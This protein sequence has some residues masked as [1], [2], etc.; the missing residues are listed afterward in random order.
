MK[1]ITIGLLTYNRASV[2]PRAIE[3]AINQTYSNLE[4]I[5][6]D[7][8]SSD[9]TYNVILPYLNDSRVRYIRRPS[10]GMTQN[11]IQ[12]LNDARGEYFMWLCDDDYLSNNYI[13]RNYFFLAQNPDFSLSCG[14]TIFFNER[15]FLDR[16]EYIDLKDNSSIKRIIKYFNEVNSNIILYGLMRREQILELSYPNVFGADII[17]SCQIVFMG[18][19][20]IDNDTLFYYSTQGISDNT[21]TLSKYYQSN[22]IKRNPYNDLLNAVRKLITYRGKVFK[23][24]TFIKRIFLTLKVLIVIRERFLMPK[25]EAKIRGFLKI[26]T[27]LESIIKLSIKKNA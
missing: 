10:I 25:F 24:I 15:E 17:W 8:N 3:S 12:T 19:V 1:L 18:K 26:K 5:I 11:F 2:I 27:R 9:N 21:D 22:G 20:Y 6:S 4:I 14:K 23:R 7:D 16:Q 13:E